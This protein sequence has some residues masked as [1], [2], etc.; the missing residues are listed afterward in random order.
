MSP[1]WAPSTNL[2]SPRDVSTSSRQKY[3]KRKSETYFLVLTPTTVVY[4]P[5]LSTCDHLYRGGIPKRG[6]Y[7]PPSCSGHTYHAW[8]YLP[9]AVRPFKRDHARGPT[10][11]QHLVRHNVGPTGPSLKH[12]YAARLLSELSAGFNL[13]WNEHAE[14]LR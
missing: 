1:W 8:S 13:M 2:S 6:S 5:Q 7:L 11:L 14:G 12:H 10:Y 9:H 4:L 3:K